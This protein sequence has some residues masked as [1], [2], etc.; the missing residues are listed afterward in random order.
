MIYVISSA[1]SKMDINTNPQTWGELKQEIVKADSYYNGIIN[2]FKAVIRRAGSE[3]LNTTLEY[4]SAVIPQGVNVTVILT[5]K[6]QQGANENFISNCFDYEGTPSLETL[7]D[8]IEEAS[9]RG[10]VTFAKLLR[11][12]VGDN[13]EVNDVY[14]EIY[15][16]F[17]TNNYTH[18]K[19]DDLQ[20]FVI[21]VTQKL[22]ELEVNVTGSD[23]GDIDTTLD[24]NHMFTKKLVD[25]T[26][27][28]KSIVNRLNINDNNIDI[29][30]DRLNTIEDLLN[31][32]DSTRENEIV[33]NEINSLN[34]LK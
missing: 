4:D 21:D 1:G 15:D 26:E 6:K 33:A 20:N 25:L 24:G 27:Q 3:T 23:S 2:D 9:H 34:N 22:Y 32:I 13:V 7:I 31:I 30:V 10:R 5:Q 19:S 8:E 17:T 18:M 12:Y 16:S 14:R 28:M 11:L 29:I